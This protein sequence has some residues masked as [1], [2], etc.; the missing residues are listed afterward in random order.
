MI[1]IIITGIHFR[2]E[3]GRTFFPIPYRD[4]IIQNAQSNGLDP[5]LVAAVISVESGFDPNAVSSRGA[6]GLMQVMPE[7][8]QWVG[9]Q[10]GRTDITKDTLRSHETNIYVGTWYLRYLLNQLD[11]DEVLSLAA[12]NAGWNRVQDWRKQKVWSGK[13]DELHQ[14]PFPETRKYV[15]RVLWYYRVYSYLYPENQD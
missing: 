10:V 5:E 6:I 14:I 9:K 3:I 11:Q 12:Y 2:R 8:G 1:G 7:T 15:E 13:V 4:V